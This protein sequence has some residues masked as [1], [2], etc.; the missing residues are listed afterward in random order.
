MAQPTFI[1]DCP[2]CKA[3]VAAEEQGRAKHSFFDDEASEPVG[4]RISV[5]PCPRCKSLLVGVSYQRRLK[6]I[7]AMNMMIGQS[8]SE[9]SQ[10]PP[11]HSPAIEFR[12]CD[13]FA[14]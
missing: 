8:Q 11:R 4:Q 6:A 3:K 14:D 5:G 13:D 10:S 12:I 7:R 2:Y 1:V 9:C